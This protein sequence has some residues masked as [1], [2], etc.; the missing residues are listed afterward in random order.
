MRNASK[1]GLL[2]SE[3]PQTT[4]GI[5]SESINI[6]PRKESLIPSAAEPYDDGEWLARA[7][8]G[9]PSFLAIS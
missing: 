9:A 5:N 7:N 8:V 2:L 1:H 4:V 3:R 6:S